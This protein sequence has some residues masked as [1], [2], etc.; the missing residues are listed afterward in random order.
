MKKMLLN[1]LYPWV[2][3]DME[4]LPADQII[5][6]PH[7]DPTPGSKKVWDL[8]EGSTLW[9]KSRCVGINYQEEFKKHDLDIDNYERKSS[10]TLTG[11][12][13]EALNADLD[14]NYQGQARYE[15]WGKIPETH[16]KEVTV[17]EFQVKS[18]QTSFLAVNIPID[19]FE[20][21]VL[22]CRSL[23]IFEIEVPNQAAVDYYTSSGFFVTTQDEWKEILDGANVPDDIKGIS[24]KE[25]AVLGRWEGTMYDP[26][27]PRY[28]S[29]WVEKLENLKTEI[30]KILK[31]KNVCLPMKGKII[32]SLIKKYYANL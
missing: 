24:F 1:I 7:P 23:G 20:M 29:P 16:D 19:S 22:P 17:S 26:D 4:D 25:G 5:Y 10:Y 6:L 21:S 32:N 13:W 28:H 9:R 8:W 14:T 12:S 27:E 18:D 15:F 11:R 31:K 3:E 2:Y 30:D